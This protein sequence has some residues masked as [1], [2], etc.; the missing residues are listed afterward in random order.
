MSKN[1][2]TTVKEKTLN[3]VQN[4]IAQLQQGGFKLPQNYSAENALQSAWLILQDVQTRDKKPALEACSQNTIAMS[5]F[6]MVQLGLNPA[7]NQCYFI[8]YGN[9]LV[10]MPSYFGEVMI[11][12]RVG[13]QDV[14]ANLIM[15][16]DDF[17][18]KIEADGRKIITEHKQ[19]F[20]NLGKKIIGAYCVITL[21]DGAQDADIMTIEEIK[22]SWNQG[23]TKGSSPAHKNFEGEMA[24]KTVTNRAV[25]VFINSSDD[26]KLFEGLL[27]ETPAE[28]H[29]NN[30]IQENANKNEIGFDNEDY[31][32][33]EHEEIDQEAENERLYAEAMAEEAGST[34][35][36]GPGF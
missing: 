13:L 8:P 19:S 31:E 27:N 14:K 10:C 15:E 28:V 35:S 18:Y 6:K 1:Q 4:R 3:N 32:E 26:A 33:A 2:L 12:K 22:Q 9:D 16:G 34:N 21:P 36:K 30:Q 23:A 29:V 11:A 17:N 25:K 7:K 5:L 20:S 24:K